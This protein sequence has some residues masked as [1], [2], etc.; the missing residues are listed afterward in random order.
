MHLLRGATAILAFVVALLA[1]AL[2]LYGLASA[3]AFAAQTQQPID[4]WWLI[5]GLI[6]CV[7]GV[8]CFFISRAID[9]EH[10]PVRDYRKRAGKVRSRS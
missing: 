2:G 5:G 7:V 6:A 1:L 10:G 9:P 4:P 8:L 3:W